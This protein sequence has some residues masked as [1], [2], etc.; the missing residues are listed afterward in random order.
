M[1]KKNSAGPK[2]FSQKK[3]RQMKVG[4]NNK[5]NITNI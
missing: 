5:H 2:W 4:E 3:N 1:E